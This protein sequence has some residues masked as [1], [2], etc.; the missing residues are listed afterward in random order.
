M[1]DS[2]VVI[3]LPL[4]DSYGGHSSSL[5]SLDWLDVAT[6]LPNWLLILMWQNLVVRDRVILEEASW[7]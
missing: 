2:E 7:L 6:T 3:I 5:L 4:I 1:T